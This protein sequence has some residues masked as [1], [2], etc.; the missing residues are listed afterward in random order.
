M[1]YSEDAT[2][3]QNHAKKKKRER[4]FEFLASLNN[5]D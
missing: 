3:L 4:I 2:M 5:K 1:K